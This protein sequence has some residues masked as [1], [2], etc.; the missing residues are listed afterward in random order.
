MHARLFG[1]LGYVVRRKLKLDENQART[2]RL[3][4][5]LALYVRGL[6]QHLD[7]DLEIDMHSAQ[8]SFLFS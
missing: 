1:T 2:L 7:S 6:Q 5:S 8:F 3:L 4:L